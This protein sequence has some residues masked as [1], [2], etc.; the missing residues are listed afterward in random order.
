MIR[1]MLISDSAMTKNSIKNKILLGLIC[2]ML[3]IPTTIIEAQQNLTKLDTKRIHFGILMGLN[4]SHFLVIHSENFTTNSSILVTDSPWSPGFN[5]GIIS[6]LKLGKRFDLRSTMPTLSF[7]E[8][9]LRYTEI[10]NNETVVTTNT[11]ESIFLDF[12][13]SL[14]YKSDRFYDNFRFYILGG[15]KAGVDLASNSKKRRAD[16]IVKLGT[17]DAG[18]EFGFGFEIYFPYFMFTPEIKFYQGLNNIHVKTPGLNYSD[19]IEKLKS[20]T[21]S[22]SLQFEG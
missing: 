20:R 4:R 7:A 17:W 6:N 19:V 8:K 14:K 3:F 10:V 18:I 1:Y 16:N 9:D 11:I 2:F 21:I 22:I 15:G 5:L 13:L 12:P